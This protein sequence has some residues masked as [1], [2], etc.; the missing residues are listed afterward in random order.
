LAIQ[1]AVGFVGTVDSRTTI[2]PRFASTTPGA[3][4]TRRVAQN[5]VDQALKSSVFL[6]TVSLS[7][8]YRLF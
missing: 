8:G 4:E 5:W 7:L 3:A 6:P 2:T 1:T